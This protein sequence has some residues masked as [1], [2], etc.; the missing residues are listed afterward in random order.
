MKVMVFAYQ[1]IGYAALSYLLKYQKPILAVVTHKDDLRERI[2]F[3]SVANLAWSHNLPVHYAEDMDAKTLYNLVRHLQPEMILSFYYRNIIPSKILNQAR[4][5]GLNLHGS[6]LPKYR[7]RAPANWVLINDEKKTGITLHE[8]IA[9]PDAGCIVAQREIPI[10]PRETIKTLY[11]KMVKQTR[12]LLK[13]WYPKIEQGDYPRVVQDESQASYYGRRKA[14]DGK[15][16]WNWNSRKIDCLVRAVTEP[17]PGAFTYINDDKLVIWE[18]QPKVGCGYSP[19]KLYLDN[20]RKMCIST[21][22]GAY[23]IDRYTYEGDDSLQKLVLDKG[24][25]QCVF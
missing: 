2:W 23:Q 4:L 5:G 13:E 19:G 17:Y 1:S 18:G 11:D 20:E 14:E 7:G 22:D 12:E 8:M 25:V 15:I 9:K 21:S 10:E 24:G 6:L 16:N 3:P